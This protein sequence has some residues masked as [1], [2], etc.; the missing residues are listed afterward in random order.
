LR[1]APDLLV[2]TNAYGGGMEGDDE[3]V[4]LQIEAQRADHA[5]ERAVREMETVEHAL[6]RRLKEFEHDEEERAR[7]IRDR[8][9]IAQPDFD[10]HVVSG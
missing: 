7:R 2:L 10:Q 5:V 6:E 9:R 8:M 4:R 3:L 1:P